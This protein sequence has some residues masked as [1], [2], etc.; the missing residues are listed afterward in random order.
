M[1]AASTP[2]MAP[3]RARTCWKIDGALLD[4]LASFGGS[5]VVVVDLDGGGVF[6]L[7]SQIDVEDLHEAAQQQA[8]AD[9]QHAGQSHFS[10]DE[11]GAEALML[12][13]LAGAGAGVFERLLQI[14][15]GHA[16]AGNEAEE[17]GSEDR[18]EDSPAEGGAVDVQRA[19]A[20]AARWRPDGA[21]QAT[22][23]AREAESEDGSRA[24]ENEAFGQQLAHDARA[25]GAESACAWRTPWSA[26]RRGP[27]EGWRG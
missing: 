4:A 21:S 7:E 1:P 22:S 13:A 19:R 15:A 8:R 3:T 2:G 18:D 23:T 25:A 9:E 27:A 26:R 14:A 24:G 11:D 16:Q 17:D 5:V 10:D 12:A 6:R 20:G